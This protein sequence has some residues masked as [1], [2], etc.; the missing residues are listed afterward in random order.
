MDKLETGNSEEDGT[1]PQQHLQYVGGSGGT[2]KSWF[3]QAIERVFTIKGVRKEMVITAMSG[4]AAAGIDGNTVHSA[5]GLT[6]KD[7]E[8][9]GQENMPTARQ[10]KANSA[11]AAEN[12]S[13]SMRSARLGCI[14]CSRWIRS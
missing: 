1:Q 11:G 4:T 10:R 12:Y 13:S 3:I 6:F 8:D 2:G 9:Q 14:R 5:L 7:R